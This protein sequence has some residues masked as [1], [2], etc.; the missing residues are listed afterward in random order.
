MIGKSNK[1]TVKYPN[2]PWQQIKNNKNMDRYFREFSTFCLIAI[3]TSAIAT[4]P[5]DAAKYL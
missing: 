5:R 2:N 3:K 1:L 4:R